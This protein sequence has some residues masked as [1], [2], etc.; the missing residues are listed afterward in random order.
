MNP[1]YSTVIIVL[2]ALVSVKLDSMTRK[3]EHKMRTY[4]KI[5]MLTLMISGYFLLLKPGGNDI[6]EL[7]GG[8][9]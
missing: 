6:E 7:L 4:L 1:L 9:Y 8:E 5:G 3:H 2:L